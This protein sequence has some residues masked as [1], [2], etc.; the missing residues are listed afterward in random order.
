M[1]P[2]YPINFTIGI[3]ESREHRVLRFKTPKRQKTS[4][5]AKSAFAHSSS[6]FLSTDLK[7]ELFYIQGL[8]ESIG[9]NHHGETFSDSG[10]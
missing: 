6:L 4:F 9:H 2:A 10:R 1:N 7:S 3:D 5:F 8:I